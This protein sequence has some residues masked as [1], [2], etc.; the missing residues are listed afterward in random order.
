MDDSCTFDDDDGH[1]DTGSSPLKE[2]VWER[3]GQKKEGDEEAKEDVEDCRCVSKRHVEEQQEEQARDPELEDACTF[4]QG[5]VATQGRERTPSLDGTDDYPHV[6]VYLSSGSTLR[7]KVDFLR[8][9]HER[10]MQRLNA[11]RDEMLAAAGKARQELAGEKAL[12][13][14]VSHETVSY[15]NFCASARLGCSVYVNL[16]IQV[17]KNTGLEEG[18]LGSLG[19]YGWINVSG[20]DI[21]HVEGATYP[22]NEQRVNVLAFSVPLASNG[23]SG[24]ATHVNVNISAVGG[25]TCI[26]ADSE[27]T[28]IDSLYKT[29]QSLITAGY[30]IRVHGFSLTKV[31]GRVEI[32]KHLVMRL[33][34]HKQAELEALFKTQEKKRRAGNVIRTQADV[35][36]PP[37]ALPINRCRCWVCHGRLVSAADEYAGT[38]KRK[39]KIAEEE[40]KSLVK[41]AIRED[42]VIITGTM[43]CKHV[44]AAIRRDSR[45]WPLSERRKS[46]K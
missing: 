31:S 40:K 33:G 12:S 16:G 46:S 10:F 8:P 19:G 29:A 41:L 44:D 18:K 22:R 39:R 14:Y 38:K 35:P 21:V 5:V 3:V 37:T 6:T 26:S 32:P 1:E 15:F 7:V 4:D 42:S 27:E 36:V 23:R 43:N 28:C 17:E 34:E 9:R 45:N 30:P 20:A 13:K 25:M 24:D 2:V 11:W